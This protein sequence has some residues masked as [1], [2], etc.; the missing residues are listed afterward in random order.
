MRKVKGST[1]KKLLLHCAKGAHS[2]GNVSTKSYVPFVDYHNYC[3]NRSH[4]IF[5]YYDLVCHCYC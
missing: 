5:V 3:M 2:G 1:E 4:H